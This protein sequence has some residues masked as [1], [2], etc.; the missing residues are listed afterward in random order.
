M[1]VSAPPRA[2]FSLEEA[3]QMLDISRTTLYR[4]TSDRDRHGR[5]QKP[6]PHH[7]IAGTGRHFTQGDID[8]ILAAFQR[9]IQ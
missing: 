6:L 2:L 1:T 7:N 5:P 4:L 9:G 3:A 8:A